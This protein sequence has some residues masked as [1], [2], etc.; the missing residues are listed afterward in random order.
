MVMLLCP[1]RGCRLPLASAERRLVCA[2]AHSFDIARRGWVNLL[3]PQDRRSA[4]PG[5][6]AEAVRARSRLRRI[7]TERHFVDAIGAMVPVRPADAVLDV[8]CGDGAH[9]AAIVGRTACEGHGLDISARA[10][11]AAAAAH[12]GL[13]WVVANADRFLPYADES[14][15]AVVS[16][17][18][19]VNATEFRRVLRDDGMLLVVVPAPDDL[20]ELRTAVLGEGIARER[21]ARVLEACA[22]VF[23]LDRRERLRGRER[24]DTAAVA[25][26]LTA[27]Y[28]GGRTRERERA[29]ALGAIDVTLARDVV[30]FRPRRVPGSTPA[31]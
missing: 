9:V 3:Q 14:F 28:R 1:V 13:H 5:D 15:A 10:V 2:R 7:G 21:T 4:R 16:V 22:P 26:V 6:T 18:A 30:I 17:T 11:E 25:D 12:P 23:T 29:E 20:I 8:G 31:R 24:L 19:R 27:T